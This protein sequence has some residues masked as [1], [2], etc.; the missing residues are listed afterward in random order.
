[1]LVILGALKYIWPFVDGDRSPIRINTHY[2]AA[3]IDI[4]IING[5]AKDISKVAKEMGDR[6]GWAR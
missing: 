1:M 6:T 5:T 3:L 4:N 2:F